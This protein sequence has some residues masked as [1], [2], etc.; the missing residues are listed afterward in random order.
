MK[1]ILIILFFC[2]TISGFTQNIIP[3]EEKKFYF[4]NDL[5]FPQNT[6]FKDVNHL[7][8]A[9]I[10]TWAGWDN[11]KYYELFITKETL[12]YTPEEADFSQLDELQ[13]RYRITDTNGTVIFDT[14]TLP[15]NS[16]YVI[17]GAYFNEQGTYYTL[18][19]TGPDC[20]DYGIL[21][22][23]VYSNQINLAIDYIPMYPEGIVESNPCVPNFLFPVDQRIV[24]T[25]Q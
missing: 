15:A 24:L 23:F 16:I 2:S 17:K 9:Y 4:D 25:K 21:S 8:D 14:S 20:G 1:N 6:Y 3:I 11:G 13:I 12:T 22:V 18:N 7:F 10:G 19:Y 5:V